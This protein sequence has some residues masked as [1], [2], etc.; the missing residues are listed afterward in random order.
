MDF[1]RP[2]EEP[3][4]QAETRRMQNALMSLGEFEQGDI[5]T[6]RLAIG[7]TTDV[8]YSGHVDIANEP[9]PANLKLI[10]LRNLQSELEQVRVVLEVGGTEDQVHGSITAQFT[11][12]SVHMRTSISRNEHTEGDQTIEH[13]M[14]KEAGMAV[15]TKLLEFIKECADQLDSQVTHIVKKASPLST[16]DWDYKFKD[17]LEECGYEPWK[18]KYWKKLYT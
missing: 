4:L 9:Y 15:Y 1:E 5:S 13:T 7:E 2:N 3:Q 14:P 6:R 8:S 10:E 17:L 18:G 12:D 16:E 11:G